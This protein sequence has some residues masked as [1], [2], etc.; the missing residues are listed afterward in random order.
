MMDSRERIPLIG[1]TP[2]R[3]NRL[4]LVSG[5]VALTLVALWSARNAL[6]PY[7]FALV[8]AYL[9]LPAVNRLDR[10]LRATFR[11]LKFT[12]PLAIALVYLLMTALVALFFMLALPVMG[13]QFA[14]LWENRDALI[15]QGQELTG[16]GLVWY[17]EN[18]PREIQT[19][20]E[21][22]LQQAAGTIGRAI[23]NSVARTLAV[24]T[25]TISFVL[26]LVVVPFWLFYIL[27]DQ[28]EVAEGVKNLV[29]ARWR[30]DVLNLARITD[31]ILSAYIR[32]QFLLCIFVGGMATIGLTLL[33]VQFSAILGLISGVTEIIP[34]LG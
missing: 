2:A 33:G 16:Q 8:L 21:D 24:V 13:Q 1:W 9:V 34:F 27:N 32:G 26:A 7:V 10:W 3:R 6:F 31:D 12:R 23:Q 18:V 5:L 30:A 20:V 22:T 28:S 17:R 14:R 19:Q 11:D 15:Q 4:L 29:P 25:S